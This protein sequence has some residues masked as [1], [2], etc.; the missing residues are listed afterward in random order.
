MK[1]KFTCKKCGQ[2][3]GSAC[4]KQLPFLHCPWYR[5][6]QG[7]MHGC[8]YCRSCGAVYDTIGSF[9]ALIKLLFLR[10]PSKVIAVYEFSEFMK[11]T[12]INNP[13]F[14]GLRSMNPYIIDTMIEDGRLM[15]DEDLME[16]PTL[17]FLLEC[18]TDKN[19]IIRKEAIIAL[20]R[21]K[22]NQ[23]I[24]PLIKAL[25]D[26]HWDVRRNTAITL[27]ETGDK[28]ALK[29]LNKLLEKELWEHLV[30]EEAKKAINK[31]KEAGRD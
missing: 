28:K 6:F 21:F 10:M 1:N 13:D 25:K 27:G 12:K 3:G 11:I 20:R 30:R 16:E 31:I 26:E 15:R 4:L 17:D 22:D 24:D 8:L 2:T 7:L 9:S 14:S 29:P 18:L 19:F 23:T 5:D